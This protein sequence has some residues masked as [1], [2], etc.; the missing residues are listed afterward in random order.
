[1]MFDIDLLK[2]YNDK[3]GHLAGDRLLRKVGE[4][5]RSSIRSIDI[6]ARYG[7]DEFAIIL[8]GTGVNAAYTVAERTRKTIESEVGTPDVPITTSI[9]V[10]SWPLD[11]SM[12][13]ELIAK[14]D[15]ALYQAKL[16]GRNKTCISSDLMPTKIS[17]T[18]LKQESI[19]TSPSLVHALALAAN[20]DAKD[21]Y[22]AGHSQKVSQY[23]V[24]LAEAIGLP[25]EKTDT[26]RAAG[27]IHD[28][29][30]IAIP[31]YILR[32]EGPLTDEEW[33][34]IKA[35]TKLGMEIA[36]QIN[37]L[38]ACIPAILHHHEH[39]DGK[40]GYPDS[41]KGETIPLEARILSI[42]DAYDA[43][44]SPRPYRK[45]LLPLEALNEL[46]HYAGSQFDP[47]L[48]D[49]FCKIIESTL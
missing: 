40:G 6:P 26:I 48:V 41:L 15:A 33:H 32:K 38:V 21:Y 8:P 25:Q 36:S 4:C 3:Y 11:A 1:M 27:L 5:L 20:I 2:T 47:E 23:A 16:T 30:K 28:I 45:Q 19:V 14:A 39:Y 24:A 7:G 29:G 22:T 49:T 31:D 17:S 13:E 18:R 37:E 34:L 12:K 43:M 10:A 42:A 46:K 9:G 35:H 44:T